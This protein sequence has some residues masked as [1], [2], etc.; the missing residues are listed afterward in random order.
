[1]D[2]AASTRWNPHCEFYWLETIASYIYR[3]Q[4]AKYIHL[5]GIHPG[6]SIC[7]GIST[8]YRAYAALRCRCTTHIPEGWIQVFLIRQKSFSIDKFSKWPHLPTLTAGLWSAEEIQL[9]KQTKKRKKSDCERY[10]HSA[11]H[12]VIQCI[13]ICSSV[14][15]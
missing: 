1:M 5:P 3:L 13:P 14:P 4:Y 7:R 9:K 11:V 2:L 8:G 10:L 15:G 6:I 12:C